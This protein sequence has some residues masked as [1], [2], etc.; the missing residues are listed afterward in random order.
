MAGELLAATITGQTVYAHIIN[1]QAKLW[2]GSTFETYTGGNYSA[3][4]VT[5]TEQGT[6][7]VYVGNFPTSIVSSDNYQLIYYTQSGG[8]P[9]T[10]DVIVSSGYI[11]WTGTATTIPATASGYGLSFIKMQTFVAQQ[12][13]L[14]MTDSTN[15]SNIKQ[16]I[17]TIQQ[18]IGG[19]WTWNF[20]KG[21]E[22]IQTVVDKTAGTMSPVNGS[23]NVS[24]LSTNFDVNDVGKYI[25][26]QGANDWYKVI[27]VLS[28]R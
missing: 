12:T 1:S 2:N 3:Y 10:G 24:G 25:Q 14:D 18:D 7:G 13:G 6:S 28:S 4:T 19:R 22:M 20:L 5:M 21:R 11:T 8:S 23:G 16:W 15:L 27:Q 26:F 9:A 17:N